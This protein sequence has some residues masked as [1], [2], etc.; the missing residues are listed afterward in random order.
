MAKR[1]RTR[2]N[3]RGNRGPRPGAR[4]AVGSPRGG[5]L[6]A[7]EEARAA[8][9]EAQIVA[10][11]AAAQG[12]RSRSRERKRTDDLLRDDGAPRTRSGSL[13]AIRGEQ[14]Y[15]YVVRD[16]RRIATVGGSLIVV[17]IALYFLIEVVGV[18]R[19]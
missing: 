16:V 12:E 1:Q 8:E 6:S 5:G 9:I 17:L 18:V 2:A 14:E 13:L 7:S 4:P 3:A 10:Q 19:L 11:E 15:T